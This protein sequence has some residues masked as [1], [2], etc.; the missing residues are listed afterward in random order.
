M[1]RGVWSKKNIEQIKNS[2]DMFSTIFLF[3]IIKAIILFHFSVYGG[4]YDVF[5]TKTC[6]KVYERI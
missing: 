3:V 6:A 5:S 1:E 4:S 2:R